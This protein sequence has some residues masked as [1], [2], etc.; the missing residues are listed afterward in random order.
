MSSPETGGPAPAGT[1]KHRRSDRILAPIPIRVIGSDISGVGF[2]EDTTTV[3]FNKHGASISLTHSLLPDDVILI[4]N[5]RTNIEEEFRVVGALQHVFGERSEWGV[6]AL[7]PET[8]IWGVEF[9]PPP[10]GTQPK[11]LIECG[12]CLSVVQSPMYSIEYDVLLMTGL[13]SRHCNRCG[14]TTRWRPSQQTDLPAMVMEVRRP[15]PST[16]R[17]KAKRLRLVMRVRARNAWGVIDVA[18]T[19]DVAKAGLC[20][21]SPKVFTVGEEIHMI[22]PFAANSV[23]VESKAKIIW[24]NLAEGSASRYYGVFYLK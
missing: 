18:Q 13:I 3:S 20:F 1:E 12:A 24:S 5:K 8:N 2:S 11:A 15:A 6:E 9:T 10:E 23:P 4:L 21:L 22:L 16:D 14:E 19:R 17:R 7:N